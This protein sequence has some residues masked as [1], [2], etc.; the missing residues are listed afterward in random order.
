M[1]IYV[2]RHFVISAGVTLTYFLMLAAAAWA[3]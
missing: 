2:R 1:D 3:N